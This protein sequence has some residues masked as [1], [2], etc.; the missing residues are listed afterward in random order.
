[1]KRLIIPIAILAVIIAVWLIQSNLEKK[2]LKLASIGN[3]LELDTDKITKFVSWGKGDSI[4]IYQE[5]NVWYVEDSFP[6]KA[7]PEVIATMLNASSQIIAENIISQNPEKQASFEV[8]SIS[9]MHVQF[10]R[11]AKLLAHAII[12]KMAP[13][14]THTYIRLPGS[15]DVYQAAGRLNYMYNRPLTGWLDRTILS[16]L[17]GNIST[18]KFIYPDN[19]LRITRQDTGWTVSKPPYLEEFSADQMQIDQ[20]INSILDFRASDFKNASDSGLVDF[21]NPSLILDIALMDGSMEKL[22]FGAE[23][24]DGSRRY[25]LREGIAETYVIKQSRMENLKANYSKFLLSEN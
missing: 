8:D 24:P 6:R 2:Q 15:D 16:L 18:V 20:F 9:G 25:C 11:D 17:S 14:Y 4:V 19:E 3:F 5:N 23:N 21:E 12:G 10:Y 7:N 22:T 13:G 1:M